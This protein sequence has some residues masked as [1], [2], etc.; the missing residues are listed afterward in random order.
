MI[1]YKDKSFDSWQDVV[2][3]YPAMWVVFDKAE[4]KH[5]QIQSGNVMAI[6]PDEETI[7]V[8]WRESV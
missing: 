5:R 4:L 6:L 2:I 7:A 3:N 1:T 8:H